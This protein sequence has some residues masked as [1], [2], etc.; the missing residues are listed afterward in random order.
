[1]N[2]KGFALVD[3]SANPDLVVVGSTMFLN[4]TTTGSSCGGYGGWGWGYPSYGYPGYGYYYPY[5][6]PYSYSQNY[7]TLLM[8]VLDNKNADH[9]AQEIKVIWTGRVAGG[10]N[11]NYSMQDDRIVSGI[12]EAFAQSPYLKAT[13]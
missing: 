6:Y 4:V 13:E 3:T 5:C 9:V 1:M 7:G 2:G 11:S 12:D 8:E 10:D